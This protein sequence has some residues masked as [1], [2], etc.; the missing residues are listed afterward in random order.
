[1][2]VFPRE[3]RNKESRVKDETDCVIKPLVV[4]EGMMATLMGYDP[5]T[6]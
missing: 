2:A 5:N 3:V 6:G 4:T 1:M